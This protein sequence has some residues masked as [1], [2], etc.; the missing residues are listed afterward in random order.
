MPSQQAERKENQRE[1]RRRDRERRSVVGY[2]TARFCLCSA[3]KARV[4]GDMI[5]G[6]RV[7]QALQALKF[8]HRP[9]SQPQMER[10]L[11]SVLAS[12]PDAQTRMDSLYVGD[13]WADVAGMLKR[14]HPRAFGRA[15]RI[16]KRLC[17]ISMEVVERQ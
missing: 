9:S 6:M 5:R 17:H 3:R 14:F 2:G 8:T 10:L 11:K 1:N 15:A 13:V 7:D 12:I 16:R 4:V